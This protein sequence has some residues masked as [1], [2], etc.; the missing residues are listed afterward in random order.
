MS[1][2]NPFAHHTNN[3]FASRGCDI[4]QAMSYAQDMITALPPE[5][6]AHATTALMV[7]VNTAANAFDQAQGPSPEKLA[8]QDMVAT[9][10]AAQVEK[11]EQRI[12]Y[13][14]DDWM[15]D[16]L[17]DKMD[18]HLDDK[19]R[20]WMNDNLEGMMEGEALCEAIRDAFRNNLS[21]SIN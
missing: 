1:T 15:A 11:I 20:D 8:V 12:N 14:I 2:N 21:I 19:I 16:N 4:D 6:H 5:M 10:V 3:L 18:D 9:L 7:V 13:M 17:S